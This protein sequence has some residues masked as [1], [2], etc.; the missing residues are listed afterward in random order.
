MVDTIGYKTIS[1]YFDA[2]KNGLKPFTIREVEEGDPRIVVIS[3]FI[4]GEIDELDI[5]ITDPQTDE[6]FL[7]PVKY[8]DF[9]K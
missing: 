7:R 2:E 3:R 5:V 4:T 1:K 6:N 9:W 8:A